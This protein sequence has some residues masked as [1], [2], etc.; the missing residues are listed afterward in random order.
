ME[1]LERYLQINQEVYGAQ[2]RSVL[3]TREVQRELDDRETLPGKCWYFFR[4]SHCYVEMDG[5]P[6]TACDGLDKRLELEPISLTK[7]RYVSHRL[8]SRPDATLPGLRIPQ[9]ELGLFRVGQR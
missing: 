8:V 3:G 9:M 4:G 7:I 6:S 5:R 2:R 1:V